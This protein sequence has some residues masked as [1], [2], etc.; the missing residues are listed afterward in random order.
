MKKLSGKRSQRKWD[1]MGMMTCLYLNIWPVSW[2]SPAAGAM[3]MYGVVSWVTIIAAKAKEDS[4]SACMREKK[5]RLKL[6]QQEEFWSIVYWLNFLQIKPEKLP[7][8]SFNLQLLVWLFCK[9]ISFLMWLS[10]R[11]RTQSTL[12][13]HNAFEE[14]GDSGSA[15]H[16][17]GLSKW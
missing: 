13:T 17:T 1:K 6:G 12:F 4:R 7:Q 3:R 11:K 5:A 16:S 10:F 9:L 2:S 15:S 14:T 8:V